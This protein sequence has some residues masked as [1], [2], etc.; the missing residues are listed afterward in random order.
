MRRAYEGTAV[1]IAMGAT[2]LPD[3][4]RYAV[5]ANIGTFR[6]QTAFGGTL[7]VRVSDNVVLNGAVGTGFGYGGVGGRGGLTYAW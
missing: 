7:Q 5:S 3:N 1:A 2:T 6:G 4:K